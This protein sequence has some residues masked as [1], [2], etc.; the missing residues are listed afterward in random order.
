MRTKVLLPDSGPLF[1]FVAV[2]D[3]LDLLLAAGLPL[4]LTDYIA[5]EATRS[6]SATARAIE[7]WI[8]AHPDAIRVVETELGQARIAKE[9]SGTAAKADRRN[10]GEITVFEALAS[11]DAG[12]GPFLFLFEEDKFVD[13]GFYGRHPVHSVTTL[14]YLVGLERSGLIPDADAVFA[15]MRANG[16]AGVKAV[17]LDRPHRGTRDGTDTSWRP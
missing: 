14:G 4:V 17:A 5:W 8:A 3:G 16:R 12:E 15:A 2:P 10:I 7:A 11:G 9:R 1:S 6:R 13:P